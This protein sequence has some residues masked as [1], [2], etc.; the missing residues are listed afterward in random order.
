MKILVLVRRVIDPYVVVRLAPEGGD[1]VREQQPHTLNPFDEVALASAARLRRED[2][3]SELV[4]LAIG[5][6]RA[7]DTLRTALA[8]GA[9]RAIHLLT[10]AEASPTPIEIAAALRQIIDE[11]QPALVTMG[12]QGSEDDAHETAPLLAGFLGWSYL[13]DAQ[14]MAME[15]GGVRTSFDLN[16]AIVRAFAP[17]PCVVSCDLQLAAAGPIGLAQ[18]MQARRKP[19]S[20]RPFSDLCIEPRPGPKRIALSQPP[21]HPPCRLV[22]DAGELVAALQAEGV[23]P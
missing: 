23:L 14:A 15:A 17:L 4:A 21:A 8:M 19:L 18:V 13:P 9:D 5:P 10:K 11:E 3:A 16:G 22:A 20:S 2:A 1:I 7:A 6:D 12:K